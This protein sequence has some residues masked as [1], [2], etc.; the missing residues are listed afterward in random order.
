MIAC[1]VSSRVSLFSASQRMQE[2]QVNESV[3]SLE[4]S[5]PIVCKPMTGLLTD[6]FCGLRGCLLCYSVHHRL[7]TSLIDALFTTEPEAVKATIPPIQWLNRHAA[8]Q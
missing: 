5:Q 8:V 1:A 2:C 7:V 3:C 6:S 4:S